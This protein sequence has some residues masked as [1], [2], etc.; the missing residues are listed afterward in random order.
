MN[1][2]ELAFAR[3]DR[4][5]AREPPERR[6]LSRDEV[7][8]LVSS[9]AGE[10]HSRFFELS[11]WLQRGDLLV[12]NR[13]A[14]LPAALPARGPF[15][16]FLVDLSTDFGSRLWLAEP[17]WAFDRPGPLPLEAGM[18]LEV[19]SVGARAVGRYPG[20]PRL[21][22][23]RFEADPRPAMREL[24]RPIRYGY[25]AGAFPLAE[26]QTLFSQVPGSAEMPSAARPFTPRVLTALEARGVAVASVLLHT[27]VSSLEVMADEVEREELLPEPFEVG[28]AAVAAIR[29]T[30]AAAGRVIAVGTTVVRALEAAAGGGELGPRRGFTRRRLAPGVPVR[31]VDGLITGFHDPYASHLALL[32][33]LFGADR[34]RRAYSAAVEGGYLWHEFGDSHLW[35][36]D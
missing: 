3:P 8:L 7:R 5:Q 14:T 16:E 26:Y 15:G 23:L 24:G 28:E 31:V 35:L 36:P 9:P 32:F 22:F 4:L 33:A 21:W 18:R 29:R 34:V 17:R 30:K 13:S 11:G 25:A 20:Q 2:D 1:R 12:V 19:G 27:G 6:G 10:R